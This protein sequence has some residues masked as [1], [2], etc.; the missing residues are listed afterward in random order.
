VRQSPSL[1]AKHEAGLV[2]ALL[3]D[4]DVQAKRLAYPFV[5]DGPIVE[6]NKQ[7][8]EAIAVSLP[9]VPALPAVDADLEWSEQI[10]LQ[11][12]K[13]RHGVAITG[14]VGM[15]RSAGE[16]ADERARAA[17][18]GERQ[19]CFEAERRMYRTQI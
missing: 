10:Y 19:P 18:R 12:G 13:N 17:A 14:S 16:R 6:E 4:A 8:E 2:D 9:V 5:A 11:H 7:G 15:L 3:K 1:V